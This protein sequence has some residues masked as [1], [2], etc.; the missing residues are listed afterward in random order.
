MRGAAVLLLLVLAACREDMAEQR[1]F[2]A[3][4]PSD[5]WPDGAASRPLVEGTI[6]RGALADAQAAAVPPAVTAALV[7]RGRER[8]DI[9]CA[10]CHG[11]T[12]RGD[13]RVV[14]RG[15]PAPP[16]YMS[17]RL[18]QAPARHFFDV[19]THGFGVMY[20]YADRVPPQDRWAIVAYVRALQTADPTITADSPARAAVPVG[21]RGDG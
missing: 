21:G 12:G 7:E 14:Q 11:L 10:P 19:V 6:A 20:P 8:Y 15:F 3:Y 4:D 13:G 18:R 5:L 17:E 16:S 1:K 2:T 9:F